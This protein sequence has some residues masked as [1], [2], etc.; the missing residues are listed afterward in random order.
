MTPLIK[1]NITNKNSKT[2]KIKELKNL[3]QIDP[4]TIEIIDVDIKNKH[5]IQI[6]LCVE[7]NNND[8]VKNEKKDIILKMQ[9]AVR[10]YFCLDV[11][12][13][14]KI[15]KIFF[16]ITN[17]NDTPIIYIDSKYSIKQIKNYQI[18][19]IENIEYNKYK[20]F[21]NNTKDIKSIY[22]WTKF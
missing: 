4:Y 9:C 2:F 5:F 7:W 17:N 14:K 18:K 20:E 21:K 10:E 6:W 11:R 22:K 16:N 12:F 13:A 1:E 3:L 19:I 15:S 8:N